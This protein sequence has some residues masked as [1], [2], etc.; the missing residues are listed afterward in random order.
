M[1]IEN[2]FKKNTYNGEIVLGKYSTGYPIYV[3]P[4]K[5]VEGTIKGIARMINN[6][7]TTSQDLKS[8]LEINSERLGIDQETLLALALDT[9]DSNQESKDF[10]STNEGEQGDVS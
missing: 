3:H 6:P 7:A 2:F 4:E 5:R 9:I 1:G 10:D 8:C